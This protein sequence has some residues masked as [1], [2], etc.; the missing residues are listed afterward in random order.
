MAAGLSAGKLALVLVAFALLTKKAKAKD[1]VA[2]SKGAE[3][4]R[5]SS[6]EGDVKTWAQVRFAACLAEVKKRGETDDANAKEIALSVLAHWSIETGAGA[7]EWNFNVANVIATSSE[8]FFT[9]KDI[10][11]LTMQFRAFDSLAQAVAAY[12][13]V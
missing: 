10:S 6:Y 5:K 9:A 8:P 7:S 12:F 1:V 13:D 11:G 4:P 2:T 3:V